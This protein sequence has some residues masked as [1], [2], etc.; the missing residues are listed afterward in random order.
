VSQVKLLFYLP[1]RDN[2][3]RDLAPEIEQVENELFLYLNGWT[4]QGYV[5]GVYE[6][7]DGTRSLDES[8]A[9]VVIT[10]E[11]NIELIEQILGEFKSKTSQDAIYLEIQRDIDIRFI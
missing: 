10:E 4:F 7:P 2:D 1:L 6:M 8:A 3:G 11:Q 5:R 9:Y